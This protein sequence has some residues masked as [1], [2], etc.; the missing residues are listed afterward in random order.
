MPHEFCDR[1]MELLAQKEE[2][3]KKALVAMQRTNELQ[4][5]VVKMKGNFQYNA[6]K[7]S[8]AEIDVKRWEA[9]VRAIRKRIDERRLYE[10]IV[11]VMRTGTL[12]E[13][14]KA[15]KIEVG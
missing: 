12:E 3:E 7:E 14:E 8:V 15:L 13:L 6:Y 1:A 11:E 5:Q 2:A 10:T 9:C 4:D